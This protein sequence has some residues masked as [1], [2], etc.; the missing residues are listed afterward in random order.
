MKKLSIVFA[1]I[2]A[3]AISVNAQSIETGLKIKAAGAL[4]FG[5][6]QGQG[7]KTGTA[8]IGVGYQ[9]CNYVYAGLEFGVLGPVQSDIKSA[10]WALPLKGNVE[11]TVPTQ[12]FATPLVDLSFGGS[13]AA[14]GKK[15]N[16][17]TKYTIFEALPGCAFKLSDLIALQANV[18]YAMI[19][20]KTATENTLMAKV[21]IVFSL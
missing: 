17:D 5:K 11:F 2:L 4:T 9:F 21:G 7:D 12:G 3:A 1:L 10:L 14:F 18:G 8:E 13:V 19:K 6:Y 16:R 20:G 15:E